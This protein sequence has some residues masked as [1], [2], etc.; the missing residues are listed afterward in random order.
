MS[1]QFR[2]T[3]S[4]LA[5]IICSVVLSSCKVV[6]GQQNAESAN[7]FDTST[8]QKTVEGFLR[9]PGNGDQ[10]AALKYVTPSA[11]PED[12]FIPEQL[13]KKASNRISEINVGEA[14]NSKAHGTMVSYSYKADGRTVKSKAAVKSSPYGGY[15]LRN[16]PDNDSDDRPCQWS[17]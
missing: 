9:A 6:P 11:R 2:T 12:D 13:I 16:D 4:A 14:E 7:V 1:K 17:S 5:A 10:A 15:R 3:I 8:P